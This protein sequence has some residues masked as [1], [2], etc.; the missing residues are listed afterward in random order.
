MQVNPDCDLKVSDSGFS[1][2]TSC[3]Y[4]QNLQLMS[5]HSLLASLSHFFNSIL[6]FCFF[7]RTTEKVPSLLLLFTFFKCL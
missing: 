2:K 1:L 4:Y 7:P 3:C 6:S 5:K